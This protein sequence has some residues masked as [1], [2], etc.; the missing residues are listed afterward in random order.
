MDISHNRIRIYTLHR[1]SPARHAYPDGKEK[2]RVNAVLQTFGIP[3]SSGK[4]GH[5]GGGILC[6]RKRALEHFPIS[7]LP[8]KLPPEVGANRRPFGCDD[9]VDA[10]ITQ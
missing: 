4:G 6:D 2:G 9:A 7:V 5:D 10:G 1:Y 3:P 8:R